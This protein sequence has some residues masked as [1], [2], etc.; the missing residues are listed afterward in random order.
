MKVTGKMQVS[1]PNC[2]YRKSSRFEILK[3]RDR[4]AS[5]VVFLAIVLVFSIIVPAAVAQLPSNTNTTATPIP[6][7]GHDYLGDLTETVNPANGSISVRLPVIMP[8]GRGITLPFS[9]AYDSNGVNY[10]ARNPG[11]NLWWYTIT[12]ATY[13]QGGWSNSIPIVTATQLAWS[14]TNDTGQHINCKG[15]VNY[16]FQ[17]AKGNRHKLDLAVYSDP[18]GTGP[19]SYNTDDWP[20]GFDGIVATQG[21]EGPILATTTDI[22]GQTTT[23]TVV[24]TDGDGTVL[25]FSGT[26]SPLV[27]SSVT[28]R[29][30]NIINYSGNSY[31][32]TAGRTA[33]QDSGFGVSPESVT[34]SGLGAPYG[35]TWTPLSLPSFSTPVTTLSGSCT[36]PTHSGPWSNKGVTQLTLP[37]TKSFTF[38]YDSTYGLVN[39]ITYPTGG[40]IRYVWGINSQAEGTYCTLNGAIT[41]TILYGVPVVT[42]RYVSF[43]GSTEILHQ[44][45]AYST[46]WSGGSWTGKQTTVTTTDAARGTSFATIY[47]YSS[48]PGDIP[49]DTASGAIGGGSVPPQIPVESSVAYYDTGGALLKTVYKSWANERLLSSQE[50]K[51]PNGQATETTWSYNSNEMVTEQDDYDF[52]TTALPNPPGP[53]LKKTVTSY[54]SFGSNHIVDKPANVKTYDSTG[55]TLV[56]ETDFGYDETVP[57]SV[58]SVV[59]HSGGCQCGNATTVSVWVNSSGTK[60]KTTHTYDTTGQVLSTTDPALNATTYSYADSFSSGG[61]TGGVSNAYVTTVTHPQTSGIGHVEHFSYAYASGEVTSSTDQN[62]LVT[63]Y[64]YNDSLARLTETDSPDGGMTTISYNDAAYNPSTPSPSITTTKKI[65][66][67]TNVVTVSAMD[68]LG[69]VVRKEVTSDPQGVV[70][71]DTAYDGM[72]RVMSSS[73][74]YRSGTDATGSPGTTSYNYDAIGRKIAETAPDGSVIATSY[75]A[76]STLVTDPTARWRRS[77]TDGL[78]RLVE[79]DEPNAVGASVAST[80]CPGTGEPIWVTSYT[81]DTLGNLTKVVQNG[82]RQRTFTYDFLSRLTFSYNPETRGVTYNYDSDASCAS[83]NSFPGL[84]VSKVDSRGIR[85]CAQYDAL[86][87]VT[88]ISYSNGDPSITTTYDQSSCLGLSSCNNIGYRTSVADGAGSEAWAY[89]VDMTNLRSVHREQRTTNSSPSNITR[90]ATYYL[91]LAGSITQLMYPTGRAVNY[92]YDAA[93]RPATAFDASSG[94]TYVTGWQTPPASTNCTAS[95]VCYTPQGSV[96]GMSLGQTSSFTGVNVLESFN[97][98][99]QPNEIKAF[100]TA[101]TV[102]DISYN[103]VDPASGHN[104]GHVYSVTNNLISGRTQSFTYDQVN[105]ILSA[106]TAATSGAYCWGYQYFYDVWGNLHGQTSWTPNYN[107]CSETITGNVGVDALNRLMT[108]TYDG[109][110]NTVRDSVGNS[111]GWNAESQMRYANGVAYVYDGDGRRAARV[112]SKLYWY[113]SGGEILAETDAA[114]NTLNEYVFFGGK[115]VAVIPASGSVLYYTEDLLGSSRAITQSNGTLCYDADFTPFGFERAYTSTCAQ[116]YKFEGKERDSEGQNDNFGAREY[117]SRF[118]RWLSADWSAVPVAVPYANLTNPQTL[119]LYAMVADDPESFADLDGHQDGQ[120]QT[121]NYGQGG[122]CDVQGCKKRGQPGNNSGTVAVAQEK[123]QNRKPLTPAQIKKAFYTQHGKDFNSAVQKVFG[124]DASK[125]PTQTLANSP[126]LDTSKSRADLSQMKGMKEPVEG[127][128][129]PDM[130]QYPAGPIAAQNGTIYVSSDIVKSGDMPEIFGTYAHELGNLLDMQ[131][132]ARE[133][134]YGNPNDPVDKDTGQQVEKAEFPY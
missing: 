44:H 101:G 27:V 42:D 73:N 94:V 17:D 23:G 126:K 132:N 6:G 47:T 99:L 28:D 12:G 61:P 56:A 15:Y 67:S 8:Q 82:S 133:T 98:R 103:F 26:A 108:F 52:G 127:F 53:L 38:A 130:S 10:L 131:I 105:R 125:V 84:L 5:S 93:G 64:K 117:S 19:C 66:Y 54:A 74:P 63:S 109:S 78:G 129:R 77:R 31:V 72:A 13:S 107:S 9:F 21:G 68:G 55:S 110:G 104:A 18:A 36:A 113:G 116:N 29:N 96:Y 102:L 16:V 122:P 86:N 80:G 34:V 14:T 123:A 20:Y 76:G 118:G 71:T 88:Q 2:T 43:D 24:V 60:L 7:A 41:G 33:L 92:S 119:N 121:P 11:G 51:Y 79:V 75:C 1:P 40:Y 90:T 35:L 58:A 59:Q 70:Y 81:V 25:R 50:T 95:A 69:H 37:N 30:G 45:F 91:N 57:T 128:N 22:Q 65:N 48:I 100:S 89:Q 112:G 115:R 97:A 87:R 114:G 134:T 111:Y 124:K 39:K 4:C 62:N 3:N 106:G 49:P 83:P 120:Q 46:T 32:D 85:S